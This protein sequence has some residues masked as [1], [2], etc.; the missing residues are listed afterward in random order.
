MA[1]VANFAHLPDESNYANEEYLSVV[2]VKQSACQYEVART[3]LVYE[4]CVLKNYF[5][6]CSCNFDDVYSAWHSDGRIRAKIEQCPAG[7]LN[8][9]DSAVGTADANCAVGSNYF[10]LIV[11]N[12][13]NAAYFYT[14]NIKEVCPTC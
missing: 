9:S 13:S 1:A 14:F 3:L 11:F 8:F 6:C 4:L 12:G 7:G 2:A 5:S 10:Y